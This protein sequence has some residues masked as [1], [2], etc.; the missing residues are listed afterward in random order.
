MAKLK[1]TYEMI[2]KICDAIRMGVPAIVACRS[3]GISKDTYY[4]WIKYGK[5]R[6][7]KIFSDFYDAL[8]E[9]DA[10]AEKRLVQILYQYSFSDWRAA[11]EILKRRFRDRWSDNIELTHE[12]DIKVDFV[13]ED[14]LRKVING[15]G[16]NGNE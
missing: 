13:S 2:N 7:S 15:E 6:K 1:L 10:D 14:V 16:E 8:E 3:V 11:L 12:G 5:E 4:R 9:A